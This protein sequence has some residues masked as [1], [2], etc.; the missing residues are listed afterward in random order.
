MSDISNIV[1]DFFN[2][3]I[4][5]DANYRPEGSSSPSA[6]KIIIDRDFY[7]ENPFGSTG[8]ATKI[9]QATVKTSDFEN[10]K[11]NETIEAE[12][13]TY[14]IKEVRISDGISILILSKNQVK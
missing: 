12:S 10:A 2:D 11:I 14:Y 13:V 5:V 7:E 9:I 1:D 4:A 8:I 3:D 6:V